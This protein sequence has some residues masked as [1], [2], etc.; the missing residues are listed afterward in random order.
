MSAAERIAITS[1]LEG[2][3]RERVACQETHFT[4]TIGRKKSNVHKK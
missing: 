2:E 4:R 1:K 3:E